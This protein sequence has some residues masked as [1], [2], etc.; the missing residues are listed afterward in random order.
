MLGRNHATFGAVAALAVAPMISSDPSTIAIA[1]GCSAGA[2]VVPDLD[3]PK[4]S[5]SNVIPLAGP[6][7]ARLVAF[8]A[9]GHRNRTHTIEAGAATTAAAWLA[10]SNR[11]AASTM[12]AVLIC[13]AAALLGPHLRLVSVAS[14]AEFFV[15]GAVGAAVY[16][17]DSIPVDWLPKAVAVGFLT[18]LLT[19][20]LTIRGIR[21]IL[22]VP[23]MKLRL[24]L[25]RTGGFTENTI[26][27]LA[28]VALLILLVTRIGIPGV[29]PPLSDR[30]G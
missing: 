3:H 28:V 4:A 13:F 14:L 10:A 24:G 8:L 7:I 11:A 19:D 12:I 29:A 20:A 22:I 27:A 26:G 5:V 18:H 17:I 6:L 2:A 1:A 25:L 15:A 16:W 23:K 9:G 30:F 21:P